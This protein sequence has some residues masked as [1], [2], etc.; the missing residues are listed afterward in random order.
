ML[1]HRTGAEQHLKVN[2]NTKIWPLK[3]LLF[4]LFIRQFL[5]NLLKYTYKHQRNWISL[6]NCQTLQPG[7]HLSAADKMAIS[8]TATAMV[9]FANE[10]RK[11]GEIKGLNL[12][13]FK[14]RQRQQ[15]YL[16]IRLRCSKTESIQQILRFTI[17]NHDSLCFL[18]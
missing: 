17:K 1:R 5:W 3:F 14:D 4:K 10:M 12:S 9:I 18:L 8:C 15:P 11:G 16:K 2:A 13:D 6:R 7:H